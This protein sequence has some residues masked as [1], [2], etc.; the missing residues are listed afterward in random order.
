M[1]WVVPQL[2]GK[3]KRNRQTRLSSFEKEPVPAVRFFGTRVTGVLAHCP[4]TTPV[5]RRMDAAGVWVLTRTSLR[6]TVYRVNQ[7]ATAGSADV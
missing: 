2:R 1:V 3:V 6:W 4:V 7:D 5:H